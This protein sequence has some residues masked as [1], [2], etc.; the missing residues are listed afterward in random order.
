MSAAVSEAVRDAVA[1]CTELR[2]YAAR[3]KAG[4]QNTP[5]ANY[6]HRQ[7]SAMETCLAALQEGSGALPASQSVPTQPLEPLLADLERLALAATP[8][9]WYPE[10]DKADQ[11]RHVWTHIDDEPIL[12]AVVMGDES[13]DVTP[14]PSSNAAFIAA[15]NPDTVLKLI[16]AVRA[17]EA[18]M[19]P[20]AKCDQPLRFDV[21]ERIRAFDFKAHY[22]EA[23]YERLADDLSAQPNHPRDREEG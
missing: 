7:F 17:S 8:G 15:A 10:L 13:D 6:Y 21:L 12:V 16:A 4:T 11:L 23:E 14:E 22:A 20:K 19:E 5:G 1:M 2:D 3:M 9:H 18:G